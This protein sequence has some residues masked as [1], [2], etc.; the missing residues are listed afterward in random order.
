M[1]TATATLAAA[2]SPA[3]ALLSLRR[4]APAAA[5]IRFPGLRVGSGCRHIA[6][7][8]AAHSRA[9]T[10]PL[11]KGADLFFRA[12]ISNMEKVYLSRNPTAKT[13]L[14][15][16]NGYGINSLSDFFTDF[17][18]LPREELRFPAKKLRAL[19]FSPP[20]N[21]GYSGT[22]TYGPLPRIFISELL[23]DELTTQSQEIIHKYIKTSGNG[24]NHA[25]IASTSGELTWEKPIYSD[26]QI[27]SRESEYAAWT[28][29]NGY[30]LNHA[31]IATHRL[32][33][34][35][36][37]I[38]KFNKFVEDN[39]FKLNSEGG[40]LKGLLHQ[41]IIVLQYEF[42][43]KGPLHHFLGIVVVRLLDGLFLQQRQ[44]TP[45]I[46]QCAV[47]LGCK[48]CATPVD[49]Q[50]KVYLYMHDLWKPHL[51]AVKWILWYLPVSPDGLLQQSSTVADSSLFTFA[52]GITESIPRSYIEFAER[53]LLPQFKDLQDEEVKEYHRRDGF[54]VGNADK[55]FESTSKD[56]LTRRSA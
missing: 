21:D 8:S 42:V 31:T 38:N 51:S 1:S 35:I 13:I 56:Q 19:W 23:V 33:S 40:I 22:G 34:D 36:R 11:P 3:V 32:E 5:P 53:L 52:D 54:E 10:D 2:R 41:I 12:V 4:R 25:A 14:E 37:S 45:D 17:G 6:M 46:L 55:I 20:T 9:P 49:M 28:L 48:R 43:M 44:Y 16:V 27:L 47:M 50:A 29:V 30:A 15:L 39:G 24:N 26:F 18:Y 7:A